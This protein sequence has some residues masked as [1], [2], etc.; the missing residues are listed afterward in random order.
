M[1]KNSPAKKQKNVDE[2]TSLMRVA[3]EHL[4][5]SKTPTTVPEDEADVFGKSWAYEYRKLAADQQVLVKK[6]IDDAFFKG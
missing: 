1:T 4:Q 5:K 6:V 3:V 2:T